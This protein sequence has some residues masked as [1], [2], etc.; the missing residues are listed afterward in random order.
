MSLPSNCGDNDKVSWRHLGWGQNR[1]WVGW[2]EGRWTSDT[3]CNGWMWVDACSCQEVGMTPPPGG[4]HWKSDGIFLLSLFRAIAFIKAT[5]PRFQ[6][7]LW[8]SALARVSG[9]ILEVWTQIV[10]QPSSVRIEWG[11]KIITQTCRLWW[12]C[13]CS[14]FVPISFSCP[15]MYFWGLLC[16]FAIIKLKQ[17][18][19]PWAGKGFTFSSH[20][21]LQLFLNSIMQRK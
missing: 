6:H 11:P 3:W 19:L 13:L 20:I 9:T 1:G 10:C 18:R 12:P 14:P 15:F 21:G 8:L 16:I 2:W 4:F 7:P 5:L 17:K